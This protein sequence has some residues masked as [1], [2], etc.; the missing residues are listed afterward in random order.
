MGMV[1]SPKYFISKT[2][3][4]VGVDTCGHNLLSFFLE[5]QWLFICRPSQ[6]VLELNLTRVKRTPVGPSSASR[7]D[8]GIRLSSHCGLE[9]D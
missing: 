8:S 3:Q 4:W 7:W 9:P 6:S 1:V 2:R 5:G